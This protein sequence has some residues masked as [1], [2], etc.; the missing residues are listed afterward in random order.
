[1]SMSKMDVLL[2]LKESRLHAVRSDSEGLVGAG[3]GSTESFG[4]LERGWRGCEPKEAYP[5]FRYLG[6]SNN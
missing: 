4:R 1:M 2:S 6:L 5:H 3:R